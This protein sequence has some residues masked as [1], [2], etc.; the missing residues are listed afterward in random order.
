MTDT[1]HLEHLGA[2]RT[3]YKGSPES[4][5]R[6]LLLGED[7]PLSSRPEHALFCYPANCAGERLQSK[8]FGVLRYVYLAM[9]R[10]NLCSPKWSVKAARERA[11][12]LLATANLHEGQKPQP[13]DVVVCLGTKVAEVVAEAAQVMPA[14]PFDTRFWSRFV[15][16]KPGSITMGS[17]HLVFLPHPSGRC[18]AWNDPATVHKARAAMAEV[19]KDIP[20]GGVE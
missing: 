10:T 17:G 6:I 18:R 5:G 13:W 15:D 4:C 19:A 12:V 9:W 2:C 8:I 11:K 20:W 7:N 3:A 1:L 14:R 16:E